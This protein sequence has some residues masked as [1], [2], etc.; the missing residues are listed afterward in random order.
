[1]SNVVSLHG[2]KR[3]KAVLVY[4]H[5]N[6]PITIEHFLEEIS[7]L[8]NVIEHGPDWNTLITCTVTINRTD[9]GEKQNSQEKEAR[10][11]HR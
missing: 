7:E 5:Q 9:G 10:H 2:D 8:H 6:G 1:M 11:E 4:D 3:W